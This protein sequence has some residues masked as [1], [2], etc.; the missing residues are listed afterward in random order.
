MYM[1]VDLGDILVGQWA[2]SGVRNL[3]WDPYSPTIQHDSRL[4]FI[5]RSKGVTRYCTSEGDR[6]SHPRRQRSGRH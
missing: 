1:A 4:T 3:R 2:T 6:P 5:L